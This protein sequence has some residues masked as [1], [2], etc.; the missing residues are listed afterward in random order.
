VDLYTKAVDLYTHASSCVCW[1]LVSWYVVCWHVVWLTR[2]AAASKQLAI[3]S[4][5]RI[6][7]STLPICLT[8]QE[9]G[10][11]RRHVGGGDEEQRPAR[12]QHAEETDERIHVRDG[13]TLKRRACARSTLGTMSVVNWVLCQQ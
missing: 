13:R 7:P 3:N 12:A 4:A 9:A 11:V 1:Y 2:Q 5:S 6:L 10:D 8:S